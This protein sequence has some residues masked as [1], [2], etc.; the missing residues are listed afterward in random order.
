MPLSSLDSNPNQ[1][2]T[3]NV[4]YEERLRTREQQIAATP[5]IQ[6]PSQ[7]VANAQAIGTLG[8]GA[9]SFLDNRVTARLQRKGLRQDI[10][11]A[12][13]HNDQRIKDRAAWDQYG[14]EGLA[15]AQ[16]AQQP[17]APQKKEYL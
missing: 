15:R 5:Q 4:P 8:L 12:K 10:K 2:F 11:Y 17:Q 9:A 14:Q 7:R 6:G 16:A 1:S 13:Q 3:S